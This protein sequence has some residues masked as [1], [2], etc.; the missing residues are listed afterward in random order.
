VFSENTLKTNHIWNATFE[1]G[2]KIIGTKSDEIPSVSLQLTINGGHKLDAYD[3][4]KAGLASLT[5]SM[6]NEATEN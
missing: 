4:E 6:M 1:N 3:K 2:L 5:A